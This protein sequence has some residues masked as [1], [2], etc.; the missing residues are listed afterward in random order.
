VRPLIEEGLLAPTM[1][2]TH[3]L[4]RS[5]STGPARALEGK[6]DFGPGYAM[7][8]KAEAD[9]G[10][11]SSLPDGLRWARYYCQR[12]LAYRRCGGA[13]ESGRDG[14][15]QVTAPYKTGSP[16]GGDTLNWGDVTTTRFFA[17]P[18]VR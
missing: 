17:K 15:G 4:F 7:R 13:E 1:P 16:P 2:T 8:R 9:A 18:I 10:T 3:A 14:A 5:L 12:Q 11:L 6:A